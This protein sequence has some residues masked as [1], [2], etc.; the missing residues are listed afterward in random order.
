MDCC[1]LQ[2]M[3]INTSLDATRLG[4]WRIHCYNE[5]MIVGQLVC[6]RFNGQ[7]MDEVACDDTIIDRKTS[8]IPMHVYLYYIA[9]NSID[10]SQTGTSSNIASV[11]EDDDRVNAVPGT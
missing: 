8:Y 5:K 6:V 11:T 4:I 9:F 7:C 3:L 10:N 2:C 1:I